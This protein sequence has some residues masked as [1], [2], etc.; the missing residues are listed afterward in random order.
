MLPLVIVVVESSSSLFSL[1][2][3]LALLVRVNEFRLF[4]PAIRTAPGKIK[5]AS[6]KAFLF[7]G[8]E[9][10]FLS[11]LN[12]RDCPVFHDVLWRC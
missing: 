12:A 5:P 11:A 8:G 4:V 10:E 2:L 3:A 6:P 1:L 9:N 7:G